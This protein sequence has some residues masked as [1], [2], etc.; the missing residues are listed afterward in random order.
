MGTPFNPPPGT[1]VPVSGLEWLMGI[2]VGILILS[3]VPPKYKWLVVV[4]LS[5]SGL[6]WFAKYKRRGPI[7][8]FNYIN[9]ATRYNKPL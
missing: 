7:E 6:A 8:S 5:L 9:Q 1:P 2:L 3:L 4:W